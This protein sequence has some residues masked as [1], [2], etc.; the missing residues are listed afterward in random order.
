MS[1]KI[2]LLVCLALMCLIAGITYYLGKKV[3]NGLMKYIPV[4]SFGIGVLYCYINLNFTS[5]NPNSFE[6][7][8]YVIL[9]IIFLFL[10]SIAL[11]EAVIIEIVENTKLFGKSFIV[12]RKAMKLVNVNKQ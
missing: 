1:F 8:F 4:L 12:M 11:L 7:I 3:S 5:F 2:A 9:I 6:S 10:F